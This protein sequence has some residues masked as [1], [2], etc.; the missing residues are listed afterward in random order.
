MAD[1]KVWCCRLESL[2]EAAE[3]VGRKLWSSGKLE[4]WCDFLA[5]WSWFCVVVTYLGRTLWFASIDLV[6]EIENRAGQIGEMGTLVAKS[7]AKRKV[8][9][10][11][12]EKKERKEPTSFIFIKIM[13][14]KLTFSLHSRESVP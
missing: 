3:V 6:R 7:K 4:I 5:I 9:K 1:S 13:L 2:S 8:D 11:G 14:S 10:K 12:N